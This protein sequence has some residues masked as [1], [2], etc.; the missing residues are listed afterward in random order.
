[1]GERHE[2]ARFPLLSGVLTGEQLVSLSIDAAEQLE[3]AMGNKV[4]FQK[5]V[6]NPVVQ[7]LGERLSKELLEN[8]QYIG[9]VRVVFDSLMFQ[10]LTF[11]R[12][13]LDASRR[14][15]GS[16]GEYRFHP[17]AVEWDLQLDLNEYLSGN[18]VGEIGTELSDIATGRADICVSFGPQQFVIELKKEEHDCSKAGLHKYLG[19]T[20]AY[21][22]TNMRLGFLGVL[23]LTRR[24]GPAPHLEESVWVETIVPVGSTLPR[25]VIVFRIA[26]NLQRPSEISQF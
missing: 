11:C 16:R 20:I 1:M 23:D 25:H 4:W 13:R 10:V 17:D 24:A 8:D 21:Q 26:G 22:V 3:A 7:C 12:S 18:L 14:K 5:E 2:G 6:G 9:N 15:L 19:Q